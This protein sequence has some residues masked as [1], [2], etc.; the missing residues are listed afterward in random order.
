MKAQLF[1]IGIFPWLMIAATV[2]LYVPFP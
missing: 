2:L 1:N